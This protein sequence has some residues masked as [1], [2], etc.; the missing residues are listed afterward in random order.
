MGHKSEKTA[1]GKDEKK[2]WVPMSRHHKEASSETDIKIALL[3]RP[4]T[5]P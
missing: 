5:V 4:I 2:D 3:T 1:Y